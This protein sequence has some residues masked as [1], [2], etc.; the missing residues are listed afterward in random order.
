MSF[1]LSHFILILFVIWRQVLS[2]TMIQPRRFF[3]TQTQNNLHRLHIS[4]TPLS[5]EWLSSFNGGISK[6]GVE[7][8]LFGGG[9][10]G[11][12][13]TVA[14]SSSVPV[15]SV[16]ADVALEVTNNR[17]PSPFVDFA[18]QEFWSACMWDQRLGLKL[19]HELKNISTTS[20]MSWINQLPES[21]N[22][23]LHWSQQDIDFAQYLP[24][25]SKVTAQRAS[26]SSFYLRWK[27]VTSPRFREL[28]SEAD[29]YRVLECCNSRAFSGAYEGSSPNDR[30][31]LLIFTVLLAVVW[32]LLQLSSVEQSVG[33]GITVGMSV[34]LRDFFLSNFAN[35]KR[36]VLCPYVDMFNHRS[37]ARSDVAFNYFSNQFELRILKDYQPGEQV[38]ISYGKPSNDRLLQ[39]YGFV[40]PGNPND[41]YDFGAT[42]PEVLLSYGDALSKSVQFPVSPDPASRL[43]FIAAAVRNTD[44]MSRKAGA[45]SEM[46]MVQSSLISGGTGTAT[47]NIN[48]RYYRTPIGGTAVGVSAHYDDVSVRCLRLFFASDS[49]FSDVLR[50]WKLPLGTTSTSGTASVNLDCVSQ[51]L[52]A[53]TEA[54][55]EACL[56]AIA[57]E[58]LRIKPTSL[59]ADEQQ[60][61]KESKVTSFSEAQRLALEFRIEKKRLLLEAQTV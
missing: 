25:N 26:W 21:F 52:S 41:L 10:R 50:A 32:P 51:P 3:S 42:L 37:D 9:L 20:K 27:S 56:R 43:Q 13:A 18:P 44:V 58:E 2:L 29:I 8:S 34:V 46:D 60:M 38:F 16:N 33:L 14:P 24:L 47:E 31:A 57:G 28:V 59:E 45:R 15:V 1:R 23:P 11:V 4:T 6:K 48:L 22:T 17:P 40:E 54:K 53:S 12:V 30:K 19:L 5:E 36:Y 39:F 49:E 7:L 61:L 35:L 55:I